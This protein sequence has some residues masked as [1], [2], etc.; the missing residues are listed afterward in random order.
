MSVERNL[1]LIRER[2]QAILKG[3]EGRLAEQKKLGKLTARDRVAMLLDPQSFVELDALCGKGAESG[4]VTGY[5]LVD[6]RAVFVYAQDYVQ[7]GGAVGAEHA[8]KVLKVMSMAQ[9]TGAPVV[10]MFDS[11]GARLLEGV[12]AVDAYAQIAAKTAALSGVVPQVALVLGQCAASAAMIAAM[13]DVVIQSEAGRLFVNGPQLV[14]ANTGKQ[15]TSEQLGGMEASSATG[16]AQMTA[17]TDAEAV[18]LARKTV[19][20]LPSNNLEDAPTDFAS[21]DDVNREAPELN[22]IDTVGDIKEVLVKVADA[23]SVLEFSAEYAPE[24]VIALG[25]IGGRTVGFVATQPS[26][27]QGSLTVKGSAKAARFISMCDSF[28][29]PLV[30]L[31]DTVG[32]AIRC[33]KGQGKLARAGAQLISALSEATTARIAVITGKAIGAGYIALASR[34]TQDVVYAWPG[35]EIAPLDAPAAVQVLMEDEL[36]GIDN[37]EQKRAQLEQDYQDNQAD[38]IN[39]AQLGYVDDVIEPAETR[40]MV[41]AALEMLATKR[42][43]RLPKKHGNLPL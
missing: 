7:A 29:I 19:M 24:M 23:G 14:S 18:A 36:K 1:P 12:N 31:V 27:D 42:D 3:D 6:G 38:G 13:N 15:V 39:A 20:L 25:A 11:T 8:R 30:S 37:P 16:I 28:N 41:A 5:G 33:E 22:V 9:K 40:M 4:V 17:K 32:M 10:A 35:A 26:V 2:K 34:P 21:V 43:A